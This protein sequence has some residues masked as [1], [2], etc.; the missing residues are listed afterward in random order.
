MVLTNT[1]R[2]AAG[3]LTQI[4]PLS[5]TLLRQFSTAAPATGAAPPPPPP[6]PPSDTIEVFV[7]DIPVQVP[8]N[9]TVLQACDAAGVDIPRYKNT[10]TNK[11]HDVYSSIA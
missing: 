1:S 2:R 3:Q 6:P 4:W 10:P 5:Q 9:F 7:D 8:R 11:L